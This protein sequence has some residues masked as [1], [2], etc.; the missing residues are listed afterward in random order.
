VEGSPK[1]EAPI[2]C[3]PIGSEKKKETKEEEKG[4]FC[5]RL[6]PEMSPP[7]QRENGPKNSSS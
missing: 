5:G 2:F 3:G 4:I 7:S 6:G 1:E